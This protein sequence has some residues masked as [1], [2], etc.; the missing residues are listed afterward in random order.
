MGNQTKTELVEIKNIIKYINNTL[1]EAE[2][3]MREGRDVQTGKRIA[4]NC[5]NILKI[6]RD[7]E[8][9]LLRTSMQKRS[10]ESALK[11]AE[12]VIKNM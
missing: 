8:K 7:L 5:I 11:H 3:M 4:N 1:Q 10:A 12:Q 2:G 6:L 9:R